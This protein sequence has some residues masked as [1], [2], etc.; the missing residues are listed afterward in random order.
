MI[1]I[2]ILVCLAVCA[3]VAAKAESA[4][5][6]NTGVSV[7]EQDPVQSFKKCIED[8]KSW[9][10]CNDAVLETSRLQSFSAGK[11]LP[12]GG[13]VWGPSG[14]EVFLESLRANRQ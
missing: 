9:K 14:S 2:G 6:Q 4:V 3:S 10:I 12:S 1:R 13:S 8:R 7:K 5:N 11:K